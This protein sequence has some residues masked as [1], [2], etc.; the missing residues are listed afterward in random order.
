M[1]EQLTDEQKAENETRAAV[2]IQSDEAAK[3][4][5]DEAWKSLSTMPTGQ[6]REFVR[7]QCGFDPGF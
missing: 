2:R 1:T 4:Q 3:A 7:K 6:A 5:T